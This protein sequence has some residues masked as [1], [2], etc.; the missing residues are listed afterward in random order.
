MNHVTGINREENKNFEKTLSKS[1]D[2]NSI[3]DY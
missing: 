3:R 1:M 2:D